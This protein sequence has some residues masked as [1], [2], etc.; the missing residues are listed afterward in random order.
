MSRLC[1]MLVL[2]GASCVVAVS[3]LA[4]LASAQ[5]VITPAPRPTVPQ[6]P[7]A[8]KKQGAFSRAEVAKNQGKLKERRLPT[9]SVA[10]QPARLPAQLTVAVLEAR[11]ARRITQMWPLFR[12]EY[13]FIR[14]ACDLNAYQRKVLARLG[15]STVKATARQFAEAELN[16]RRVEGYPDPRK[17]IE[18]ELARSLSSLLTPGQQARYK[19]EIENGPR[20]ESRSS[21]ITWLPSWTE[22]LSSAPTSEHA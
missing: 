17:L 20:V 4:A 14:N 7:L 12:A 22:T 19:E 1:D 21:S 3:F 8:E 10:V 11:A 15:E 5:A 16:G 18:N 6:P 13:Y 9:V 2:L